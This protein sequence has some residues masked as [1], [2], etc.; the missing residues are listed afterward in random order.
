MAIRVRPHVN[1][2]SILKEHQFE[3]FSNTNPIV[4]DVGA[5]KGEFSETLI[6]KYPD[7]NFILFE[8]RTPLVKKLK[9][10][11]KDHA[12]VKIFDGDAGRNFKAVIQSSLNKGINI[13]TIYINFP[14]P[15][16]KDRHKKRRFLNEKFLNQAAIYIQPETEWIFQTDQKP[17]FDDTIE[18]LQ[19]SP[20]NNIKY[21][22]TPP[23][24]IQTDWEQ[25]KVREGQEIFRM[26]FKKK[27][28]G[29]VSP[30]NVRS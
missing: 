7:R 13:E 25:A 22:N 21:F 4:I 17:L 20:F 11:F 24:N 26:K 29:E 5:C 12:N 1:P 23:F 2:F 6:K 9:E 19:N 3:G 8:I 27:S 28:A 30:A 14:D 18:I 15:W 10:K 16:P